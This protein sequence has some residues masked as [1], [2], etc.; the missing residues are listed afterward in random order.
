MILTSRWIKIIYRNK[1]SSIHEQMILM[2]LFF[3]VNQ[4]HIAV[5]VARFTNKL[6]FWASSFCWIKKIIISFLNQS[7]KTDTDVL[8]G[9]KKKMQYIYTLWG[10]KRL[11]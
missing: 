6:L 4:K 9:N 7:I 1:C 5:S 3:L 10:H 8:P 2:R 11:I